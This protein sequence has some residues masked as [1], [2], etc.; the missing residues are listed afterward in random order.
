MF[1]IVSMLFVCIC[2]CCLYGLS[3]CVIVRDC[4]LLFVFDLLLCVSMCS[5]VLLF[6]VVCVW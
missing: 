6:V 5:C 3:L 1:A 4:L 2:L